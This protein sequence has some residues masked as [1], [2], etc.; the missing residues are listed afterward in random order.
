MPALGTQSP[1]VQLTFGSLSV[2]V[3]LSCMVRLRMW[4]CVPVSLSFFSCND[5]FP[6]PFDGYVEVLCKLVE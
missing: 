4:F 2:I 5:V 6:G 1:D 3:V